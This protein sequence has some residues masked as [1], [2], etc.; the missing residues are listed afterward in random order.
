M[1][2]MLIEVPVGT[3][4]TAMETTLQNFVTSI[5][6]SW[7]WQGREVTGKRLLDVVVVKH[8]CWKA[9]LPEADRIWD[10]GEEHLDP[11]MQL[12][13]DSL[14]W[15]LVGVWEWNGNKRDVI[16]YDYTDP[17]NPVPTGEVIRAAKRLFPEQ[18]GNPLTDAL[19]LDVLNYMH[20]DVV[21]DSDGNELSRSRPTEPK[22]VHSWGWPART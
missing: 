10:E 14:G 5:R 19:F 20:D 16:V 13:I 21:Y 17:E 1:I 7:V 4:I 3:D 15:R 12:M 22:E 18:T 2:S 11:A 9:L 6:G 8:F